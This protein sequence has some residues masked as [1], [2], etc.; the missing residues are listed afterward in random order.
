MCLYK[1]AVI[2]KIKYQ[3]VTSTEKAH[4]SPLDPSHVTLVASSLINTFHFNDTNNTSSNFVKNN[5]G[6]YS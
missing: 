6:N 2:T 4:L 3:Q 5:N 1:A